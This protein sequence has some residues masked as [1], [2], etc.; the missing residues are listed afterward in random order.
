ILDTLGQIRSAYGVSLLYITH[1]IRL[2]AQLCDEVAIMASGEI[3]EQGP[4]ARILS[5]P[6]AAFTRKL[7]KAVADLDTPREASAG[8]AS[9]PQVG[10]IIEISHLTKRYGSDFVAVDDASLSFGKGDT[11]AVVG[12]SGSGKTTLGRC[13]MGVIEPTAGTI[14]LAGETVAPDAANRSP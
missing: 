9:S 1:D 11:F 12:E 14:T 8:R 5:Q 7:V 2:A 13:V 10:P 6:Q 4:T 3:V